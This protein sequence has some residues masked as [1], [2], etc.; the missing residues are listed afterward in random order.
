MNHIRISRR[1]LLRGAGAAAL[2]SRLGRLNSLAQTATPDYRALVCVF[3]FGGNDG[4]NTIIPLTQSAF[5]AY[6]TGRGSLA[7]PDN[8]GPLLQ[9]QSADGTPYGLNP[10]LA[11]IHPLWAQGR[12]AVL[13]NTGML[14]APVTRQ[15]FLSNTVAVPTNLF[16]HSDQ[17]QQMQS[18]FPSAT[19]GTGW[20][21]RTVDALHTLN[22]TSTFPAAVS[23][24]GPALFCTG[25]IVQSASLLPGFDLDV[26]GLN[27]WP[28]SASDARRTGIQQLL[29]F[30]SGLAL[31]Q[32]ANKVRKDALA[33][34]AMLRGNSAT[35]STAF[36]GTS[37]GDQ[38]LQVA[39]VIKLRTTTGMRRQVFF[40]SLGGFDTH[41]SQSW[42]HWDLLKQVSEALAAFYN[43]TAELGVADQVTSF[44]MS[45]FGRSLQPSG[46]GSDHGWGNH[47]LILG[48]AVL[49]GR[50][51]GRFPDLS[52]Q[53]PDDCGS[54]GVLIPSTS[55]EQY[56][57]TL[58][59][60]MGVS[61][62]DLPSVFGNLAN[63]GSPQQ[64]NL[65]FLG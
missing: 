34:N 15:A 46:S 30:D 22:G 29:E 64:S 48:G 10:G 62:T 47:Q 65:G 24:N 40:C 61:D 21:G 41:G 52:L 11:A 38:L 50:V 54:R 17:L 33:L 16:S 42:Q 44:T 18:G 31:I 45:D 43:A 59:R 55:T 51:Y 19:G 27:L 60:W 4:H 25:G 23:T 53:G 56:G 32:S 8:N 2:L 14:V 57:A 39:K 7:L 26:S 36:P 35:V 37:L 20:G 63:F 58:A 28:Q 12:L 3:L 6:R 5:N 9:V 49:G 13:A 1:S